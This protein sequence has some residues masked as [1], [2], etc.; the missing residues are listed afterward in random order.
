MGGWHSKSRE[1]Q[2]WDGILQAD[3]F[4]GDGSLLTNLPSGVGDVTAASNLTDET[5]VQGDGGAKGVKTSAATVTQ[6]SDNVTHSS[7]DGTDHANVV[8][9]D[10]HVAGDG[11]DHSDVALNNT[12]RADVTGDPHNIEADTLTFTNKTMNDFSNFIDADG[13]HELLRNETGSTIN[14][15][16]AVFISG[17]SVGQ[18]RALVTLADSSSAATM[19]SV[20]ILENAT[21]VNNASGHFIEIGTV[22]DMNTNSWE[23]GDELYISETGT[24][25]NT[26]TIT[27][28]TGTAL[29]QKVAVVLRKHASLGIIEVFGAGRSNDLPNVSSN[30]FWLGNGSGVPT[31]T[32][33]DTEVSANGDVIANTAKNT[34]VSTNLSMGTVDGTQYNIN[35]SDGTNVALPLADTNNWGIISDEIFDEIVVNNAKVSYV[36]T[37]V[38]GHIEHGGTAGTGRPSGF[39]SVEWIGTVEPT[40]A[41]NG[42]TWIDTT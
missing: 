18:E 9:N 13:I 1:H 4:D 26:L 14:V 12:H 10:T 19:P 37:N 23:V 6:I 31:E 3:K 22:G 5:I 41:V 7:S 33:F 42:D 15:R 21:L 35:S 39:T 32:N 24:T 8:T 17:Y 11:S 20:A 30:N 38:K 25:G 40:N 36:K 16:D 34:N 27:K 2:R 29:V 28:P